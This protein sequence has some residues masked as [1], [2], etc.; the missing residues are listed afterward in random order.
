MPYID[1]VARGSAKAASR[2]IGEPQDM[3]VL[4]SLGLAQ[5]LLE[6]TNGRYR[7]T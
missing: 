1:T 2:Y 6:I 3:A 5:A 7:G 4:L